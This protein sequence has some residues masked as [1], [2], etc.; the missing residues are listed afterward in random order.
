MI[1]ALTGKKRS[2]KDSVA[3]RLMDA[4]KMRHYAF[5]RPMKMAASVIFGWTLDDIEIYKDEI[6][7][8]FGISPRRVL[9]TLGTEW[10]QGELS[11]HDA[12]S[13]NTG[14]MLWVR[15]FAERHYRPGVNWVISD[16]RFRHEVD[17]LRQLTDVCVVQVDRPGHQ[18]VDAHISENEYIEPERVILNDGDH[19]S[20]TVQA[21]RIVDRL[22]KELRL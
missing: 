17:G 7:P 19:N 13:E 4:H 5:A 22:R 8:R 1:I 3:M 16:V 2:G 9:Q 12:F 11:K 10:A 20:L 15:I 14:R 21:D 6:D 18:T